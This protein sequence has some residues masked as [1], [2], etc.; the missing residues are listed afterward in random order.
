MT[1]ALLTIDDLHLQI[2]DKELLHGV[3]FSL[4]PGEILGVVGESGSGKTLTALSILA[5]HPT[6]AKITHGQIVYREQNLLALNEKQLQPI[7][8][9]KVGMVFQDALASLNPVRTVGAQIA[10]VIRV[11]HGL[12]R[13]AAWQRAQEW[14]A[15]VRLPNPALQARA[16]PHELSGGQRQRVMIALALAA[17]PEILLCDEPTSAL[18][19][20]VQK[21]VI[22]LLLQLKSEQNMSMLFISHDLPLV[23]EICDRIAVMRRGRVVELGTAKQVWQSPQ[24]PYTQGLLACRPRLHGNPKRLLTVQDFIDEQD[25]AKTISAQQTT[26]AAK[27]TPIASETILQVSDLHVAFPI[28][29]L[30]GMWTPPVVAVERVDFSLQRGHSLGI[31]GESGS[32]KT[33]VARCVARLLPPTGGRIEFAG[34][35]LAHMH[36][37]ALRAKRKR[38]QMVFQDPYASL[39]PAL[40]IERALTEPMAVHQI[41]ENHAQRVE[42]AAKLLTQV[43]LSADVLSRK[44][45]QFSG[46]QRQRIA[47][48]RALSVEPEVLICDESVS[49]LDVSVQAQ[50]LNLLAD[51]REQL[52]LSLIFISHDLSVIRFL[53]DKVLVMQLGRQV[54]YGDAEQIYESPT[55]DYTKKLLAAI[56]GGIA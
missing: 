26:V 44:P 52:G 19:V 3:S 25:Q 46:G 8:G 29:G 16:Y 12:G 38:F 32:G 14:L 23:S 13:A 55:S 9:R 6:A 27:S 15:R 53:C 7:R 49:A 2:A 33:T 4:Q 20:S 40:T 1:G 31:V 48:A 30:R 35:D 11:H 50:I 54:E 21:E 39:N 34:E 24:H 17:E 5:L 18:D 42:R 45:A 22:D 41:G 28:R 37:A 36:G 43:G 47:I 10:E 56:P 51:L